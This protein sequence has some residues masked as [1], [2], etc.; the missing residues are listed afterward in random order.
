MTITPSLK[1]MIT[2]T[3]MI[4]T[5]IEVLD[6]TIVVVA[7]NNMMGAFATT[8]DQITWIVTGYIISSAIMI[9]LT[10]WLVRTFGRKRLLLI[11]TLG[12]MVSSLC[13]GLSTS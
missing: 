10:G 13:C 12:F 4:C 8:Q 6:M 3:V 2:L 7:M 11:A 1:W 5:V 9:V